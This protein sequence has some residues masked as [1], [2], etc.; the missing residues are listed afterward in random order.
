[1]PSSDLLLRPL[2]HRAQL[3][4]WV[5]L[6][7]GLN[8]PARAVCPDHDP[9]LTYL[10]TAYFEPARDQVVWAPRGG[11]KT[12]LA[13]VATLLD[14]LHKP[15]S[16]LRILGGSLE[17][18]LKLWDYLLPDLRRVAGDL[19]ER[20]GG[21][22]RVALRTGSVA[23]VL[24]QS[25]RAVRGL[26]VQ[27]L[28]CDEVELFDPRV[29][30]A[31]Q[32]VTR[33]L[34]HPGGT[35]R[36]A[37]EALSTFHRPAG[38]MEQVIESA[39]TR[40]ARLT[41]WCILDVLARCEP[42]RPCAGCGL[43]NDC[44]GRAK[45]AEGFVSIDDALAM[46]ARV[47][48]ATWDAEMLCRRP[49]T[50]GAVFPMFEPTIHVVDRAPG[51]DDTLTLSIDFGFANPFVCLWIA[52]RGELVHVVD[53]YVQP[54]RTLDEHIATIRARRHLPIAWLACDPAGAGRNDQTA[55][56]S[57]QVLRQAGFVV[58]H[59]SSRIVDG[60]EM[61][62]AALRSASGA[63]RLT[64]HP[65]CR[66]LVAALRGYRYP[67]GG[68]ELPLK[69]GTHDHLVDALRYHFVNADDVGPPRGY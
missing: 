31:A 40:H 25:Q 29:W 22:R 4:H 61:V 21:A 41:R 48:E 68:G 18:S 9:P 1:M 16:Q 57:V 50:R 62:R 23:A 55:R 32:L 15:P 39:P 12:R 59:R 19:L 35:V 67:D 43:W 34:T 2:R 60:I 26:R 20:R 6:F 51:A 69:D 37:I 24:T 54:G 65:R 46:R 30:E 58:R 42:E 27:K 33:S 49:S 8:V 52:R 3:R 45:H 11:G 14:L 66:R 17:Q 64:V 38:V 44:G 13:A 28:R 63:V 36:G 5:R 10:A 53:E 7:T 56:S 47:S